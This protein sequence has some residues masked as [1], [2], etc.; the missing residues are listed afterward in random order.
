MIEETLKKIK[1]INRILG[2]AGRDDKS[3]KKSTAQN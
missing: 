1:S 3:L 2:Q